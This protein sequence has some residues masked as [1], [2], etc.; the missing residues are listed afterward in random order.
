MNPLRQLKL[1]IRLK[2]ANTV[3]EASKES[4]PASDSP[5]WSYKKSHVK[6]EKD[7]PIKDLVNEHHIIME[8][9]YT[10]H[11]LL[12]NLE[13]NKPIDKHTLKLTA[14]FIREYVIETHQE[15]EDRF[16][17]Q[18]L[19]RTHMSFTD[20]PLA[21]IKLAHAKMKK[22]AIH[23]KN[24]VKHNFENDLAIK[25]DLIETLT[26]LKNLYPSIMIKEENF[27]FPLVDNMNPISRAILFYRLK[28]FYI[29]NQRKIY[30][31]VY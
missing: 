5:A 24:L 27:L 22:L 30:H 18:A 11:D 31:S 16:L 28:K 10:I 13:E 25:I 20:C 17:I 19:E 6:K 3:D 15:K 21:E 26:Q 4:F 23:L 7:N 1:L 14:D 2:K 29:K 8:A 9:I 12:Q